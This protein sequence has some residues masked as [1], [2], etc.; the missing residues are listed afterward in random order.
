MGWDLRS[1]TLVPSPVFSVSFPR[2]AQDTR[3]QELREPACLLPAASASPSWYLT[4]RT[5]ISNS[6]S[7]MQCLGCSI[8]SQTQESNKYSFYFRVVVHYGGKSGQEH[9]QE[10]RAETVLWLWFRQLSYTGQDHVLRDGATQWARQLIVNIV[11]PTD[12][13]TVPSDLG[14]SSPEAFL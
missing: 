9:K 8:L 13:P 14:N 10:L 2:E 4:F 6:F 7:L 11:S 5:I 3:S 1:Q 12:K